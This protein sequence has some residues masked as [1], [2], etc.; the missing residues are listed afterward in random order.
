MLVKCPECGNDMSSSAASCPK[1]GHPNAETAGAPAAARKVSHTAG[2]LSL[3]AFLLASFTPAI[4]APFL[5]LAGL[6]FAAKELSGGGKVFGVIV[7]C[8]SLLQGWFVLD[9]FGRI[10]GT[11]GITTAKDVEARAV[12][13]YAAA[14]LDLP[15]DWRSIAETKCRDEWPTD[16][17]MQQH[18]LKQQTEGARTLDAGP[19]TGVDAAAFRII[20]GKCSEEWPRDFRMRAHCEKQQTEGYRALN[21]ASTGESKRNACAQQWPDDY[22]M[23]RHCETK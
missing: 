15:G 13:K 16:F 9:H 20:R 3:A 12:D 6:A 7:L 17:R 8:L 21:S 5:V 23:R 10:S 2:W 19:A 4:L 22:R 18:C 1:C 14:S 11:L